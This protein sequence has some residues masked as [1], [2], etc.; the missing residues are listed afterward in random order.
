MLGCRP[1][2]EFESR[3]DP[4]TILIPSASAQ[5]NFS[6]FCLLAASIVIVVKDFFWWM[7]SCRNGWPKAPPA[8][9][10]RTDIDIMKNVQTRLDNLK[11]E[12]R[13]KKTS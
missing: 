1:E 7:N 8:P 9:M 11:Y 2:Y 12:R 13:Y 6:A 10:M 5:A 4:T 3:N